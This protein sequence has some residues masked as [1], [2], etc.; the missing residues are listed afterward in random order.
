MGTNVILGLLFGGILP[1]IYI[2][3]MYYDEKQFK[4][5]LKEEYDDLYRKLDG[6]MERWIIMDAFDRAFQKCNKKEQ[7]QIL[8]M[9]AEQFAKDLC[10]SFNISKDKNNN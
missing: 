7:E 5:E 6:L 2:L 4:K 3:V 10:K 1:L 9:T 8:S